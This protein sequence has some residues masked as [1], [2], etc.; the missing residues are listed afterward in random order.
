MNLSE[1]RQWFFEVVGILIPGFAAV[2]IIAAFG[3]EPGDFGIRLPSPHDL[4]GLLGPPQSRVPN[5]TML[6]VLAFIVGHLVQQ[7]SVY[8]LRLH[9][10]AFRVRQRS[11]IPEVFGSTAVQ[12]F[13]LPSASKFDPSEAGLTPNDYFM[14]VYPDVAPK[15]KRDTFVALAGFSGAMALVTLLTVAL[16]VTAGI[17]RLATGAQLSIARALPCTIAG[18]GITQIWISRCTYFQSLADLVVVNY[19]LRS[20]GNNHRHQPKDALGG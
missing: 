14:M 20:Y 9:A 16:I 3:I 15:T 18:I 12:E 5:V 6:A 17:I 13:L 7:L 4:I 2:V 10:R 19:F 11:L 8:L 1:I